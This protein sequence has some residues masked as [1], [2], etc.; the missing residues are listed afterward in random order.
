MAHQPFDDK[1]E[2]DFREWKKEIRDE[3]TSG[4]KPMLAPARF[5]HTSDGR[6]I[7]VPDNGDRMLD[8]YRLPVLS[9][10]VELSENEQRKRRW[11]SALLDCPYV[12]PEL[13]GAR[14]PWAVFMNYRA[15]RLIDGHCYVVEGYDE[16]IKRW[17]SVGIGSDLYLVIHQ[18]KRRAVEDIRSLQT[19]DLAKQA[20]EARLAYLHLGPAD[21]GLRGRSLV[22]EHWKDLPYLLTRLRPC[23]AIRRIIDAGL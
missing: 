22:P 12:A 1:H 11:Y 19:S 7:L 13:V 5:E 23:I 20:L 16:Y 10:E 4:G 18:S 17:E 8:Q 14:A 3:D 2:S 6:V 15:Q 21:G 9:D